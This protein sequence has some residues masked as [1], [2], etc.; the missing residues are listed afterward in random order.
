MLLALV[1]LA[2]AAPPASDLVSVQVGDLPVVVSAPHGGRKPIPGC[3]ERTGGPAVKQFATVTDTNTDLLAEKL[4]AA[5]GKRMG[6]RPHLVVARF[7]RKYADANRPAADGVES[8]AARPHYDAYH[9]ALKAAKEAVTKGWGRGLL[10]DVHGQAAEPN[11]VFRGTN[12]GK[13]VAHLLDR[14]GR[15]AVTGPDSVLGRFAKAGHTVVPA[16][17]SD[18][19]EDRRYNG[20]HIVATYGSRDG[21]GVDAIQLECGATLRSRAN[22]DKTA[23]ALA[24]GVAAFAKAYLPAKPAR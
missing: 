1:A 3:P 12:D 7:E 6:G 2:L 11:A 16:N 15:P 24:D 4:A 9:A 5:V 23:D 8:D 21:G 10:L 18:A 22:L 13:S 20:G 17:D 19:K 14:F